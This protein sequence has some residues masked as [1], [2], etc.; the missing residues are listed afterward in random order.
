M[1][2]GRNKITLPSF[3]FMI[4]HWCLNC[5]PCLYNSL[6]CG[7]SGSLV[8][9][10]TGVSGYE[11]PLG[12]TP[13]VIGDE[14]TTSVFFCTTSIFFCIRV[15]T[16]RPDLSLGQKESHSL[17][18]GSGPSGRGSLGMDCATSGFSSIVFSQTQLNL[19]LTTMAW[20][21]VFVIKFLQK[22]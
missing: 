1:S 20:L 22:T 4:G 9:G 3:N 5:L 10:T 8:H 6:L 16:D 2:K 11:N 19:F 14:Q 18:H 15:C 13:L 17:S 21:V 7:G 12:L